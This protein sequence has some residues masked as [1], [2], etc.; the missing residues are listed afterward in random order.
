MSNATLAARLNGYVTRHLG[1]QYTA[2]DVAVYWHG[3]CLYVG[4]WSQSGRF[5]QFDLA[6][7]TKLFTT[8]AILQA[9]STGLLSLDT[10][11]TDLIPE[12]ANGQ[13]TIIDGGV[14]PHTGQTLPPD[15]RFAGQTPA[16]NAVTV[17]HLFTHTAGLAPWR[18]LYSTPPPAPSHGQLEPQQRAEYWG[19]ALALICDAPLI[20]PVGQ[21]VRYSDL[22]F[23][24]LGEVLMRL[25]GRPATPDALQA[26]QHRLIQALYDGQTPV[27][28][29]TTPDG[30]QHC[31]PT[32]FDV[33]WRQRRVWGEV[34]DEN[35]CGVGGIA[36]HAGLFGTADALAR[37]GARWCAADLPDI[38]PAL[39]RDAVRVHAETDGERR[40]L[41][42]MVRSIEKSSA[43]QCFGPHS[44]GHTGFVG[45]TLW[46]DPDQQLVVACLTNNVYLGRQKAGLFE[47]RAGLHDLVW[48]AVCT[49]S[50]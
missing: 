41:G 42:W 36:G 7:L 44:Y 8:T 47:F 49:S 12:F 19:R 21:A 48:E 16:R 13:A 20:A 15:P 29:R 10:P 40:G 11:L 38:S 50:G 14:N 6:S 34:H 43:G 4:Q 33:H 46:I 39:A 37:F 9:V 5:T 30:W 22:G 23:L 27:S 35:A 18:K 25:E 32:E 45:N 17:R 2:V 28:Y 31:A 3:Q 26:R 1:Q 24:L